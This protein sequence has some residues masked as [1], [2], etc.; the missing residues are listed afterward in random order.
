[1]C[2]LMVRECIEGGVVVV[3]F[4]IPVAVAAEREL[5]V[6]VGSAAAAAVVDRH[7][8]EVL[9]GVAVMGLGRARIWGEVVAVA[10]GLDSVVMVQL[11]VVA[12]EKKAQVDMK[13]ASVAALADPGLAAVAVSGHLCLWLETVLCSIRF[14]S[15]R[16]GRRLKGG[17][18]RVRADWRFLNLSRK[19]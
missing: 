6:V 5:A 2:G 13:S 16:G 9:A 4:E 10:F 15:G 18:S 14:R 17:D 19:T 3:V 11:A 12:V 7:S 1:M 8:L